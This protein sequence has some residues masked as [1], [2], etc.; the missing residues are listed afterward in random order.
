MYSF[1]IPITE[2]WKKLFSL[3]IS[4]THVASSSP[5]PQSN[6]KVIFQKSKINQQLEEQK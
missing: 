6:K 2:K 3:T 4:Q 1:P 5:F